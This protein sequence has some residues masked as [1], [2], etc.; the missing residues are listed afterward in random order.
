MCTDVGLT[1][2]PRRRRPHVGPAALAH[3]DAA[4][5]AGLT[6]RRAD[7][8]P[9]AGR[10]DVGATSAWAACR[11]RRRWANGGAR[12]RA[13]HADA[14][15]TAPGASGGS[16][17]QRAQRGSAAA[18]PGRGRGTSSASPRGAQRLQTPRRF[19]EVYSTALASAS[20]ARCR[21]P[22]DQSLDRAQVLQ[23]TAHAEGQ[24]CTL[25]RG[26]ALLMQ[27][28]KLALR[29]V[30]HARRRSRDPRR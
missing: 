27:L 26:L 21:P 5:G 3:R 17:Q 6:G 30:I 14:G 8:A 20:A 10:P 7:G 15:P 11:P 18:L 23:C 28:Y 4:A 12:R 24:T 29:C 13:F 22:V 9:T 19:K 1:R 25:A 16:A 2:R